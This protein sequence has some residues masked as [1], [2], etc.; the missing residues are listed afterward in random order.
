MTSMQSLSGMR[1]WLEQDVGIRRIAAYCV[2]GIFGLVAWALVQLSVNTSYEMPFVFNGTVEFTCN[3]PSLWTTVIGESRNGTL[4]CDD[5]TYREY[6]LPFVSL[7]ELVSLW[8]TVIVGFLAVF[9]A[10]ASFCAAW[11]ATDSVAARCFGR[12]LAI[13]YLSFMFVSCLYYCYRIFSCPDQT[14]R[15]NYFGVESYFHDPRNPLDLPCT[16]NC[17][18]SGDGVCDDGGPG[19][20]TYACAPGTDC[21]DCGVRVGAALGQ[22]IDCSD[23]QKYFDQGQYAEF[24]PTASNPKPDTMM[25]AAIILF[26]C[27][28]LSA[29]SSSCCYAKQLTIS[30]ST[31]LQMAVKTDAVVDAIAT[32]D[33]SSSLSDGEAYF[34]SDKGGAEEP[35]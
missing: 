8:C 1:E 19:A 22:P 21:T 32:A 3:L 24:G 2:S 6:Q 5:G 11:A 34:K 12:G 16:D 13:A 7:P 30:E 33:P 31:P 26:F 14:P 20:E 23:A 27:A 25:L 17:L 9:V 15:Y 35:K 29:W 28:A 18:S 10:L 4:R